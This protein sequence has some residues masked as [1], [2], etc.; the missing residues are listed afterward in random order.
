MRI[1][2]PTASEGGL[3]ASVCSHFGSAPFYTLVDEVSGDIEVVPNTHIQ[4]EHGS[5][6]PT[7]AVLDLGIDAVVCRG[8]GWRGPV[9]LEE[10]GVAVYWTENWGAGDALKAFR[11]GHLARAALDH[12]CRHD[13]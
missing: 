1:C 12:A 3:Q 4:H 9:M 6:D 10:N 13:P 5:C 11:A 8:V 7:A 2:I